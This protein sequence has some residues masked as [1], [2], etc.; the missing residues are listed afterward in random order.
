[1]LRLATLLMVILSMALSKKNKV[2]RVKH[3]IELDDKIDFHVKGW[4][5]QRVGWVIIFTLML[6]AAL[7]VFGEGIVSK[8]K[9]DLGN[10]Q[11]RYD[12]FFRYEAEMMLQFMISKGADSSL[13]SFS[14]DYLK[15]FRIEQ[16]VP[17]PK[18]N[19]IQSGKVY[20][21][22]SGSAPMNIA[23]YVVP[24]KAGS[25]QGEVGVNDASF[26]LSQF[27]YP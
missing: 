21:V 22:F 3:T 13:I 14:Q 7:G 5:I 2:E 11:V 9:V 17:E 24:E 10:A 16:I 20:Y 4:K 6:A 26:D 15:S 1:M 12:R 23:F 19:Y 27:I 25:L 18:E 8:R